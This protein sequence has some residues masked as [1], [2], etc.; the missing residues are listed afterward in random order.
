MFVIDMVFNKFKD[1]LEFCLNVLV[2]AH[3]LPVLV[4]DRRQLDEVILSEIND[5][6]CFGWDRGNVWF[7]GFVE[8]GV[9]FTW[10]VGVA[11]LPDSFFPGVFLDLILP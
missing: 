5:G 3:L 6:F 10:G 9:V 8:L 7:L 4:H 2:V 11:V 1:D